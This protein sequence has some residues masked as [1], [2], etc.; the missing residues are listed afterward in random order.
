MTLADTKKNQWVTVSAIGGERGFRRRLLEMGFVAGT[1]V[2]IVRVAPLGDPLE[3]EVRGG[4][5]SLRAAEAKS[6]TVAP[7]SP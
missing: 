6:I 7:G 1:P 5:L 3:L 2:R 4:R